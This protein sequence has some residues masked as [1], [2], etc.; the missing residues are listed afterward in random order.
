MMQVKKKLYFIMVLLYTIVISCN[1]TKHLGNGQNLFVGSEEKIQSS[2][3]ISHGKRKSLE[4]QMHSIVRPEPNSKFLGMRIRLAIFNLFKEPKKHKGI[5]YWLKYKVGEPPV[6]ATDVALQKNRAIM[7]NHLE[8]KGFFRDTVTMDTSVNHKK[9]KATYTAL[10]GQQYAI[11]K[12]TYPDDSSVLAQQIQKL[13]AHSRKAILLKP[14]DAYDL[15]VIKNERTRTDDY[16]KEHGFYY[17]S[18]DDLIANV[19]SAVSDHKVNINMRIKSATPAYARAPYYINNIYVF[20]DYGL[21]SDTSLEGSSKI[22][23]YTIIDPHHKFNPKIFS[24]TLVFKPG[25]IYNRTDHNLSLNRLI[26]LGIYKFV[27]VRFEPSMPD[28][29]NKLDAYYYLTPTNK[30]S[31]R[32]EVS[33]VSKSNNANG[34]QLSVNWRNRNLLKDAELFSITGL[35][36]FEKQISSGTPANTITAGLEADLYVPRIIAPVELNTNSGFVP[37]TKFQLA[38]QLYNQTS[39]YL[40]TSI[41]ANYGYIWKNS[42]VDENEFTPVNINYVQPANITPT[43]QH[44]IDTNLNLR[45]SIEK[46][47]IIGGT[48][49]YNHNSL[50]ENNNRT[51]NFYFNGNLDFS[52]NLPGLF[53][54]ARGNGSPKTIFGTP[55]SQYVRGETDFRYYRKLGSRYRSFNARLLGGVGIPYG[56]SSAM[57]FVKE[58]FAGG[59]SD[60]RG[61]RSR[62][63]GPGTYYAGNPKDSIVYDQPGDIKLLMSMEYRDK[64]FSI[65]RWALFAD[66]GNVWTLN[67]DSTRSGAQFNSHFLNQLGIDAGLGLR[68]DINFLVLRLDVAFPLRL[69]YLPQGSRANHIDFGSPGWRRNNLV[70]NLAIGYPF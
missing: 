41:I 31:I 2:V 44:A 22:D 58:F 59:A 27:K 35:G 6:I 52:G 51:N 50:A 26:T 21:H 3:P 1:N 17:F 63:F 61:F 37:Q 14:G 32:F 46:Q 64:L 54:G 69:P 19:D 68:F 10:V 40:L 57:P 55:F 67:A 48:Y 39:S 7:Q 8:N 49:N 66:A 45:R 62:T 53:T 70:W 28:T 16:L 43:F 29:T 4:S 23:G 9:L 33:A 20:A 5:I 42:T 60:M 12:V 13:N 56:N 36:G 34:T 38:Y 18:P 65:V 15:E 11:Q 24:R 30:K 25:D 47:F